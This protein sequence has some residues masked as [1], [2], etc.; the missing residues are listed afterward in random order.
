MEARS[1][2]TKFVSKLEV[3]TSKLEQVIFRVL[4]FDN[5]ASIRV[6]FQ[7]IPFQIGTGLNDTKNEL[8]CTTHIFCSEFV[9]DKKWERHEHR[10]RKTTNEFHE[11]KK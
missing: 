8:E 9:K 11:V 4:S 6:P 2:V 3:R 5:R 10:Q 1:S 7:L